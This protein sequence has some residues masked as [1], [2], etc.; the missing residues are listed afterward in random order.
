M[1][2]NITPV[3]HLGLTGTYNTR[4]I[5]GYP[6]K[7]GGMT[8]W[9]IFL[10]SDNMHALTDADKDALIDYGVRI[11]IDLRTTRET[12]TTPNRFVDSDR[13]RYVWHNIIGDERSANTAD[14]VTGVPSDRIQQAYSSWL[15]NRQNQVRAVL[16]ILAE[17]GTVTAIYHC[18]GGKDR[19]GVISALLLDIAGVS[20]QMIA[21]D[22][23]LTARYLHQRN[24]D[25]AAENGETTFATWQQ[26]Q[27]Q[28]CP[29]EA[30]L[31]TLQHLDDK[32]GG[33]PPYLKTIGLDTT[34]IRELRSALL[35]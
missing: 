7:D 6:T 16:S 14:I 17:P 25:N 4:E 13:V 22:Y 2:K 12:E 33:I 30:M 3:R 19:T 21:K 8:R 26:Y 15:D 27:A 1:V 31:K 9:R 11:V 29:P 35:G 34:Q 24:L 5:G 28:F 10:R 32:Y 23:G 18:A 20:R